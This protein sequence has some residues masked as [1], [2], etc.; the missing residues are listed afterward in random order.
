[1]STDQS[2]SEDLGYPRACDICDICQK[3]LSEKQTLD[4]TEKIHIGESSNS[5]SVCGIPYS[6]D[7]CLKMTAVS[8]KE[9][10]NLHG[11]THSGQCP[12]PCPICKIKFSCDICW[13]EFPRQYMLTKHRRI[14]R[15]YPYSCFVCQK[16]FIQKSDLAKHRLNHITKNSFSHKKYPFPCD[17]CR[18]SYATKDSLAR[19][20]RFHTAK[21][22]Y[23]C[24]TCQKTFTYKSSLKLHTMRIHQGNN[25]FPCDI[26]KKTLS[27]KYTLQR[28]KTIHTPDVEPRQSFSCDICHKTLSS[29]RNLEQHL[30]IHTGER[31]FSCSLCQQTFRFRDNLRRH[32][33][34]MH[35]G[36]KLFPAKYRSLSKQMLGRCPGRPR[37]ENRNRFFCMECGKYSAHKKNFEIHMRTHRKDTDFTCDICQRSFPWKASL[38]RHMTTH[39]K[40]G[41]TY[42]H[43][44]FQLTSTQ[45]VNLTQLTR[46]ETSQMSQEVP[47]NQINI[48]TPSE[49]PSDEQIFSCSMCAQTFGDKVHLGKHIKIQHLAENLFL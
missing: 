12:D 7:I 10:F 2:T 9:T 28:H 20:R 17:I 43:S 46:T 33:Q 5:C 40:E 14:H 47:S 3:E 15:E 22:P 30:R 8:M 21:G 32:L 35:A 18:K 37:H 23:S 16:T 45:K 27:S 29:I 34:V 24:S 39:T 38:D 36:E 42:S 44:V 25:S 49:V 6:C 41:Q 48:D 26:C 11:K 19:H 31:P 4:Q 13:E 1:M